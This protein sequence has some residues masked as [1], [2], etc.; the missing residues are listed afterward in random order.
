MLL[1][2][3]DLLLLLTDDTSGRLSVPRVEVNVLLV[4]AN[5]VELTLMGKVD[6][7]REM[8]RDRFRFVELGDPKWGGR[9][10]VRDP[11]PTGDEVLDATL[12]CAIA[13]QGRLPPAVISRLS[14]YLHLWLYNRLARR[15]M[16]RYQPRKFLGGV[17]VIDRW[18]VQE[19]PYGVE[20]RRRVTQALVGSMPPDTRSAALIALMHTIR[21]ETKILGKS[22]SAAS[23]LRIF[24]RGDQIVS[25]GWAP[26]PVRWSIG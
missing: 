14:E 26:V 7:S 8:P 20:V 19:S 1:L 25:S 3:E 24:A 21:C 15:G 2:A 11:S 6:L 5:L 12:E 23:S 22:L 18:P 9:I 13:H 4:G 16:V 10:I 17:V